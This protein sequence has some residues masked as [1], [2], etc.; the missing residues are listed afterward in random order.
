MFPKSNHI[1]HWIAVLVLAVFVI[2]VLPLF[3]S[4]SD[5]SGSLTPEDTAAATAAQAG[6]EAFFT[7]DEQGGMQAWLDRIC[8]LS[9]ES[10]C[11]FLRLGADRLWRQ[12]EAAHASITATAKPVTKAFSGTAQSHADAPMQVWAVQVELSQPLPGKSQ[13]Q[14]LT[15]VLVI[16]ENDIWKFDRFLTPAEVT[17]LSGKD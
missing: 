13:M 8:R 1:P 6:A 10:G 15:Y 3:L 17:G 2:V 12:F 4:P 5:P 7:I 14:E 11:A 16:A 9:T